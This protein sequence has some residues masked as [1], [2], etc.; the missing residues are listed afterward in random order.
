V[1]GDVVPGTYTV[2]AHDDAGDSTSQ[3][4]TVTL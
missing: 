4:L 2:L 3:V 1:P